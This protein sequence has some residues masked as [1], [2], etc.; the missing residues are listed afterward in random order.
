MSSEA[1]AGGSLL[2]CSIPVHSTRSLGRTLFVQMQEK[3]AVIDIRHVG[4]H[5]IRWP[6]LALNDAVKDSNCGDVG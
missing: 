5:P 3:V 6:S 2:L 4:Q 1:M